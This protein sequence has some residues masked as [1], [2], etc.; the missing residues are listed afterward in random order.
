[1]RKNIFS[2]LRIR[3][4]IKREKP[5]YLRPYWWTKL[6]LR[7]KMDSWR[8]P[9][10]IHS[11]MKFKEK[12]KQPLVEVG[13]GSPREVRGLLGN[14]KRPVI[15]HNVEELERLNKEKEVAVIASEVGKRKRIEIIKKAQELGIEI[16]N[17]KL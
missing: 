5:D 3:K 2:L 16:L 10:G 1:M 9:K 15:V 4:R 11:K 6:R 8:R 17:S 14:G 12:G 13:Y 7:N